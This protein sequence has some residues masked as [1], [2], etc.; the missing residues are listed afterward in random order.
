M[1]IWRTVQL[2]LHLGIQIWTLPFIQYKSPLESKVS[3]IY[4]SQCIQL[5]TRR[6]PLMK[7]HMSHGNTVFNFVETEHVIVHSWNFLIRWNT[8]VPKVLLTNTWIFVCFYILTPLVNGNGG[9]L[10]S[11]TD[12]TSNINNFPKN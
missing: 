6:S 3:S 10:L 1:A 8:Y 9:H 5:L 2:H 11:E 12:V 4:F 7:C